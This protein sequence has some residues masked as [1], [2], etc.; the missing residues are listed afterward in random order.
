MLHGIV[1][2]QSTC[3][4]AITD[5]AEPCSQPALDRRTIK[6]SD[7][8]PSTYEPSHEL[9]LGSLRESLYDIAILGLLV[10]IILSQECRPQIAPRPGFSK[11]LWTD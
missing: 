4:N 8:F 2:D 6:L 1:L 3:F 5:T 10:F 11:K 7:S 9:V